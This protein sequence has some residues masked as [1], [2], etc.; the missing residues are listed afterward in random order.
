MLAQQQC[1][2]AMITDGTRT[3]L[4][5]LESQIDID[6]DLILSAT[7]I[8]AEAKEAMLKS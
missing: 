8:G 5:M 3:V 4:L 1:C 7:K 6:Y 2:E